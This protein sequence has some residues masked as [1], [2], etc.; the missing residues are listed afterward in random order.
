M[1]LTERAIT[2]IGAPER[3]ALV[4]DVVLKN[5]WFHGRYDQALEGLQK[6]YDEQ[7]WLSHL[8]MGYMLPSL[9]RIDEAKAHVATLL[10]MKP[11][12]TIRDA[13]AYLHHVVLRASI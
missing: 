9:G 7:N 8:H 5:D 2:L 4:V 3:A 1:P 13:N 6:S 12:F 10:K 11:G